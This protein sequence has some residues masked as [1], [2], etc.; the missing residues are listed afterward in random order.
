MSPSAGSVFSIVLKADRSAATAAFHL[1]SSEVSRS[2]A[3]VKLFASSAIAIAFRVV[4][5]VRAARGPKPNGAAAA[6]VATTGTPSSSATSSFVLMPVVARIG[7][8]I[9]RHESTSL[10]ISAGSRNPSESMPAA[11]SAPAYRV[12]HA[13]PQCGRPGV[14]RA[15]H[16]HAPLAFECVPGGR[17]TRR[18]RSCGWRRRIS[19]QQC[20]RNHVIAWWLVAVWPLPRKPT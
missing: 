9:S 8:T 5:L 16:G 7:A 1:L 6:E 19:G 10:R 13:H 12:P 17:P 15:S 3:C 18:R 2:A 14:S 11:A 20:V 4:A